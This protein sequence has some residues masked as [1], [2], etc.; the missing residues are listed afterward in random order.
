MLARRLCSGCGLDYNLHRPP[1]GGRRRL[2][3]VRRH[4]GRRARTTTPRRSPSRL[5]DYHEKTRPSSSCSSARSSSPRST[6]PTRSDDPGRDPRP[7]RPPLIR[8]SPTVFGL[9]VRTD[10]V[11]RAG[12]A[13]HQA[14]VAVHD[15]QLVGARSRSRPCRRGRRGP[16]PRHRR[17]HRGRPSASSPAARA[18]WCRRRRCTA[19]RPVLQPVS[20]MISSPSITSVGVRTRAGPRKRHR[21]D[22]AL[23]LPRRA[24]Q[25]LVRS[26]TSR[27]VNVTVS[28]RRE[29]ERVAVELDR[30]LAGQQ[31]A[32]QV[33]WSISVDGSHAIS[34]M[35]IG[36]STTSSSPSIER[37][38]RRRSC[39]P[40]SRSP[41]RRRTR[42]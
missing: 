42:G 11:A 4:A 19:T 33:S 23:E 16:R 38:S 32:S 25:L 26:V 41:I 34:V 21:A 9:R 31:L 12:G 6:P 30:R 14:V 22:E 28:S 7:L 20:T 39:S 35:P 27:S 13:E 5:R 10:G 24:G 37:A 1:P 15:R 3:R 17:R 36:P 40:P 29:R 2:R 18:R 8:V